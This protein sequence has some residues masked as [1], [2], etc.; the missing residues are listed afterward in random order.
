M[1]KKNEKTS[2]PPSGDVMVDIY[3]KATA[4]RVLRVHAAGTMD[5]ECIESGKCFR[6]SG[7]ARKW[8]K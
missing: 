6:I 5:V 4:C 8:T 7:L 1:N 3:G 2:S